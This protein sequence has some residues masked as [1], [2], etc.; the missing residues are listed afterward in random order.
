MNTA[1][2]TSS[3]LQKEDFYKA[4]VQHFLDFTFEQIDNNEPPI[5]ESPETVQLLE[6]LAEIAPGFPAGKKMGELLYIFTAGF[7][8]GLEAGFNAT[9]AEQPTQQPA[10]PL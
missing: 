6:A 4:I 10:Q 8:K 1:Q 2:Q 9:D 3:A 5:S 7:M